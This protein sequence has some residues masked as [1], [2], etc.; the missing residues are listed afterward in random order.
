MIRGTTPT[1]TFSLSIDPLAIKS[2][3][4]T[5]KQEM[6][7]EEDRILTKTMDDGVTYNGE[8][9]SLTLTQEETLSF[10]E[11][12]PI[13]IQGKVLTT[14]N[15]VIPTSIKTDN[16]GRILNEEVMV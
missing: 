11:N 12:I 9:V 14:D 16:C 8:K 3:W 5:F 10:K 7:L 1:Y 13:E 2:I 15:K 4:I 6:K